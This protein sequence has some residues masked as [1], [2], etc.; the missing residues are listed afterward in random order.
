MPDEQPAAGP[1]PRD[2]TCIDLALSLNDPTPA[3]HGRPRNPDAPVARA[4]GGP[5]RDRLDDEED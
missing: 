5:G 1:E 2:H 3:R 4:F